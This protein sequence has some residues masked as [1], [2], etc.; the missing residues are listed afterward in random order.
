LSEQLKKISKL[1]E[2]D[3]SR[4][5]YIKAKLSVL[6][7]SQIKALRLKSGMQRQDDLAA[8][9]DMKQSRIS[10]I[11]TP[12]AVNFNLETL[13]RLASAFKVG[14]IVKFVPFSEMLRWE[15]DFSQDEFNVLK[16]D[17]DS[18]FLNPQKNK[19]AAQAA[20]VTTFVGTA[21]GMKKDDVIDMQVEQW[22]PWQ[23]LNQPDTIISLTG[24]IDHSFS[25]S[26][27]T[28]RRRG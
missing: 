1:K 7:P 10:A 21:Y 18:E 14:L 16:I 4:I 17:D 26:C 2:S 5:A 23:P 13:V 22:N 8:A 25:V 15:K 9:A 12:G 3:S 6:I 19:F 28:D 11:E 27:N 20:T 24:S